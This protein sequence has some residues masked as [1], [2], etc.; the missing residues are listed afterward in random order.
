M[1]IITRDRRGVHRFLRPPGL[2]GDAAGPVGSDHGGEGRLQALHAQGNLR[3]ADRGAR[4]RFSAASSQDTGKVFLEEMKLSDETLA[5]I[6][7]VTI[8]ACGTSWHAGLVGKFLIEQ[9]ARVPVE[10]DYGSEYRYR[11]PDRDAEHAGRGHHAVRAKRPTRWRRCAKPSARRRVSVGHLQRGRQHGDAR[12]RRHHL[13]PCRAGNRRGVDQGLH[14]AAGGAVSA[15]RSASGQARR[16]PLARCVSGPTSTRCCSCRSC[17]SRPLKLAPEIEEVAAPV[18]HRAPISYL[19]RGINYPIALEGA[20]KL[21]EISYI[22][23][24]GYPAGEMKHGPIALIDEQ[25]PVVALAPQDHVFEK[26]IGNMQ[27][28]KAR[29]GSVIA[30]TTPRRRIELR[31]ILEP[32]R[33]TSVLELPTRA[34]AAHADHDGRSAAVARLRHRGAP[35]LRRRSAAESRE[36]RH[37]RVMSG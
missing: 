21:K 12:D 14:L 37:G 36:E 4:D 18:P 29:G 33:A 15:R 6:E 22:H 5:G 26:M 20:L 13:H 2:E 35:R 28:V 17:S 34:G 30:L 25:M 24:E 31:S 10:V 32:V 9:L 23:A 19:G 7:R 1:A 11:E 8:L 27:E 16:R 3:A